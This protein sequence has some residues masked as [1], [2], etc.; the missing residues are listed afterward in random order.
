MPNQ[1]SP[2]WAKKSSFEVF[3]LT[4]D[5]ILGSFS[6]IKVAVKFK[7]LRVNR[8]SLV[9]RYGSLC[10]VGSTRVDQNLLKYPQ[11][12][13]MLQPHQGVGRHMNCI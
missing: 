11:R 7:I 10:E 12:Q 8:S 3:S 2:F 6:D 9:R 5:S 13:P 4:I 1:T